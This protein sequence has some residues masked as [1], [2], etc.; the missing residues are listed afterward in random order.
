MMKI[1]I[2]EKKHVEL[3]DYICDILGNVSRGGIVAYDIIINEILKKLGIEM[4]IKN[5]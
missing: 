5:D 1:I 2:D 3:R 4:E